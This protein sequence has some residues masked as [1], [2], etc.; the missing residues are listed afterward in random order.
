MLASD[1]LKH[2][3]CTW[4]THAD[5]SH[6]HKIKKRINY[7]NNKGGKALCVHQPGYLFD[8]PDLFTQPPLMK[9]LPYALAFCEQH[10][11][12]PCQG[13]SNAVIL[14]MVHTAMTSELSAAPIQD[15]HNTSVEQRIKSQPS[16]ASHGAPR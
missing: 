13:A 11:S 10:S 4:H 12:S 2:Q 7:N 5:K 1:L 16:R 8:N 6:T 3:A 9:D 14:I 15:Y